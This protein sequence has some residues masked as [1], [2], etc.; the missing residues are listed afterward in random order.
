MHNMY[1]MWLVT[2]GVAFLFVLLPSTDM[3]G[4]G[5]GIE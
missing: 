1:A 2:T 4:G 5:G 3:G